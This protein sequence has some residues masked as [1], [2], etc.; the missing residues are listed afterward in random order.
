MSDALQAAANPAVTLNQFKLDDLSQFKRERS[1][2]AGDSHD[3]RVFY[4]G[5]DDVHGALAFLLARCSRSL[6]L[7]NLSTIIALGG[8]IDLRLLVH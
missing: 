8:Q 2:P 7:N 6:R 4:V 1:F 3:F 5:R